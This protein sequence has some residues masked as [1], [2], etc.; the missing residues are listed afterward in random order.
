MIAYCEM[1]GAIVMYDRVRML[2][3]WPSRP[4]SFLGE[5]EPVPEHVHGGPVS[6]KGRKGA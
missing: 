1:A 3:R 2:G 4:V 5:P 6:R